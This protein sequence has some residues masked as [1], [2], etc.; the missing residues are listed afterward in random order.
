VRL[1]E[2]AELPM[3]AADKWLETMVERNRC[4][5][6]VG[7]YSVCS[8]N[9]WV[10]EAAMRQ[11]LEHD[12][13]ICIESTSNQ[14]NQFGGYTGLTPEQFKAYL[15]SIARRT[16]F[17]TDRILLGSDHLGPYP[18]RKETAEAALGKACELVKACVL[19]GY[20]KIHLDASMACADD[21]PNQALPDEIVAA[22]AAALSRVA[23]ATHTELADGSPAPVYIIG[24]EVPIPG[25]EQEP[26]MPPAVTHVE[27]AR[28]TLENFRSAFLKLGLDKAW[29]R[30]VGLVVQPGVEFGD[31]SVFVYDRRKA[32]LLSKCLP[33]S[34]KLVYEA[35]STDYQP[36]HALREM[37][38][39]HFAILKVGPWLTFAFRE[40]VFAL[41]EIEREWLGKRRGV[42]ISNVP[43]ALERAML[44]HPE[45]WRPYY[46]GEEWEICFARR[47]SYSDRCRY[48]WPDPS[49]QQELNRLIANLSDSPAPFT[50]LSQYCPEEYDA[51]RAGR[52]D[53]NPVSVIHHRITKVVRIYATACGGYSV[54]LKG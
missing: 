4:H 49:V 34:P 2:I 26:G 45:H 37:V 1:K 29:E 48:Y 19:A 15:G 31:T 18:W 47:Y 9:A 42:S 22:R 30:V 14:V 28:R 3:E 38:E 51:V 40:V 13:P 52:I 16:G 41:S 35:H 32:E 21:A 10:L 39:D 6:A 17:P 11:A 25:G 36:S 24:T 33:T 23:E 54:S 20:S 50:L 12:S 27:D 43:E 53:S 7:V 46:H 44:N 8:A 5:E